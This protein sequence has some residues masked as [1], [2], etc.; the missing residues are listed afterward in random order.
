[1]HKRR[2][3][4]WDETV[5]IQ[6]KSWTVKLLVITGCK[7]RLRQISSRNVELEF[8]AMKRKPK[9]KKIVVVVARQIVWLF[10]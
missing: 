2:D 7:L 1:M 6:V 9:V 4:P 8:F 10:R 5:S 3:A